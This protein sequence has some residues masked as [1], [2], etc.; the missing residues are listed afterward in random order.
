ML[1]MALMGMASDPLDFRINGDDDNMI[2]IH[3]ATHYRALILS[4]I[5]KIIRV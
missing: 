1:V 2:M 5:F 4:I 3:G